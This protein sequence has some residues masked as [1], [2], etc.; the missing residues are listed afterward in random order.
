MR[1]K[2]PIHL[3]M[4][5]SGQGVRYQKAG[6]SQP[7][8]LIPVNG[9]PMV[10]RLLSCY[11]S[12]WPAHFV[13]ASNHKKTELPSLLKKL[14]PDSNITTIEAHVQGPGYAIHSTLD[15][16]PSDHPVLVSYCD[17]GMVWDPRQFERF[18]MDS[19]CDACL[20]SYRG[21]HAHYL[22]PVTYAY[23][24]LEDQR[25]VEVKE[26]SSFTSKRENEPASAGVYYFKSAQLLR[27]ALEYQMEHEMRL[28][29]ELY[30]S[31][32]I[33]A[34]LQKYPEAHVRTFEI[35]FFFQWG[36]PEDL[37]DF[38]YWDRCF[39]AYNKS[40][41][42]QLTCN[43]VLMPMA[44][45]GSRFHSITDIRKPFIPING[46]PMFRAALQSLPQGNNTII[47]TVKEMA[48]EVQ[49]GL[50][51][52]S[53]EISKRTEEV[54]ALDSTPQG[55]ALTVY[56]GLKALK[57]DQDVLVSSCDHGIVL[58]KDLWSAFLENPDC[59]AAIFTIQNFPSVRSFP[60]SFA[61]VVPERD[62]SCFASIKQVSVKKPVSA[63][64]EKDH[65][66]VGTF[67]FRSV[68]FLKEAIEDLV[69]R[70]IRVNGELYLDSIFELMLEKGFRVRNF[71][72]DGYIG[73]GDPNSLAAALYWQEAFTGSL[74][75]VRSRFPG[76]HHATV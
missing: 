30:T 52:D 36:T 57:Q 17:F 63:E 47:V 15:K 24:R 25:V 56:A 72:L 42:Q 18:V 11:P 34:L 29:G 37:R 23:S 64:P 43:Q 54:I 10:E 41:G 62:E 5:M 28:N 14:R 31:L 66:L 50:K 9:I 67:W 22:S 35:P 27:D 33:Q 48:Q 46:V 76:V 61:Y 3:L 51:S 70:D 19:D 44:G 13:L 75:E 55:Q 39:S 21:F 73:W 69:K 74:M 45:F 16:I 49:K 6:Y 60:N 65:L 71:P 1:V 59:D 58:K 53:G 4:P 7:K 26:K 2:R 32:T 38:E 68:T 12:D 40:I 8:P 20:V